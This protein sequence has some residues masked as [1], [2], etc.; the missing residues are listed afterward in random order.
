MPFFLFLMPPSTAESYID[1]HVHTTHSDGRYSP[2][3]VIQAAV[4]RGLRAIAIT[5]HD[6][7]SGLAAGAQA[8]ARVGIEF[9]PGIEISA[10]TP[11]DGEIHV[12]GYFLDPAHPGLTAALDHQR[13]V[14]IRRIEQM[15]ARLTGLGV[16]VSIDA[17]RQAAVGSAVMG[18]PHLARVLVQQGVVASEDQAFDRFLARGRPAFALKAGL[19]H[20]AA[21]QAI[22]RAGGLPIY[23]HPGLD[24]NDALIPRLIQFGLRGLEVWHSEHSAADVR[25]YQA[26]VAQYGL[27]ATGGS[28]CHG[29]GAHAQPLLGTVPAPYRLLDQLRAAKLASDREKSA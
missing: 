21:I 7:V 15:I 29:G 22:L 20:Q 3:Q 14:R 17:V 19:S 6:T 13:T 28:D 5:D 12:L 18:R 2:Q 11:E 26:L 10:Y 23:A 1:L 27:L 25:R 16:S 9:V 4:D 24:R 8:A